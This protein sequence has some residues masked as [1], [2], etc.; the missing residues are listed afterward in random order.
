MRGFEKFCGTIYASIEP[1]RLVSFGD[2]DQSGD[3]DKSEVGEC[4]EDNDE[5]VEED[6]DEGVLLREEE[7]EEDVDD[8]GFLLRDPGVT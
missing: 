3:E 5:E 6:A 8:D 1:S 4:T 2:I 7:V